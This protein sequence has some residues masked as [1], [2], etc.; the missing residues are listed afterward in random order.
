MEY[1]P[2]NTPQILT[3]QIFLLHG[4]L[5]GTSSVGLRQIAYTMAEEQM[6]DYLSSFLVPTTVTGTY[7]WRG[8]NPLEL[9][10]G[11]LILIR[12]VK[13]N[14]V[15]NSSSCES[16][17]TE[18]CSIIRNEKYG[19]IDVW[20]LLSCGGCSGVVANPYSITVAYESGLP[21]GT[22]SSPSNQPTFLQALVLAAQINLNELDVALANESIA[23]IGL[24][25]FSSQRYSEIRMTLSHSAFGNSPV[26]NR[27]SRLVRKLRGRPA[28]GF[29]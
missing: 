2:Y 20:K 25:S 15:D 19:Y 29:H 16:N 18:A 8:Q 24:K 7:L 12:S 21:T 11:H 6:T 13:V 14:S 4:G 17:S 22:S 9:D 1:Y 26:A 5:T 27:I 3:D 28:I 23:D 10:H